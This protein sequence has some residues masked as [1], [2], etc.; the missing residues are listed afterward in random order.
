M[1]KRIN[2]IDEDRLQY[3]K[4]LIDKVGR[5]TAAAAFVAFCE[6]CDH[7]L[8]GHHCEH[9]LIPITSSGTGCPYF[10]KDKGWRVHT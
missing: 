5:E 1:A 10:I 4:R 9:N 6:Q 3:Q 2:T 7:F 8:L